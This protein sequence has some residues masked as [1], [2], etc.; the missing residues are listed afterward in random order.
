MVIEA[1]PIPLRPL[2]LSRGAIAIAGTTGVLV[3]FLPFLPHVS[4]V[5]AMTEMYGYWRLALPALLSI[6]ILAAYVVWDVRGRMF[7]AG[8]VTL[9]A[10]AIATAFLIIW[11]IMTTMEEGGRALLFAALGALAL[12]GA[13][14]VL[15]LRNSKSG[16]PH[17]L[18]PVAALQ[19][20]YISHVVFCV[21]AFVYPGLFGFPN[22]SFAGWGVG[23]YLSV[24]TIVL[25]AGQVWTAM[26]T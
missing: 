5:E 10:L 17:A 19:I 11:N 24:A 3:P 26:R 7:G 14:G 13:G 25:Y 2:F 18:H 21:V 23:A 9:Y 1:K 4:P 8:S 22:F 6:P 12:L 16:K 15:L 20:C